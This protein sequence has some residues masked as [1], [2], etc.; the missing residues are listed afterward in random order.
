MLS[1][2]GTNFSSP[3]RLRGKQTF[4]SRPLAGSA[5]CTYA[6]C[7]SGKRNGCFRVGSGGKQTLAGAT[8]Q[9]LALI[10]L[11]QRAPPDAII[12]TPLEKLRREP[13]SACRRRPETVRQPVL[14]NKP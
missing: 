11:T 3:K 12:V 9:R 5:H 8:L 2:T 6:R 7:L 14:P 1:Q 13:A 4:L 10:D